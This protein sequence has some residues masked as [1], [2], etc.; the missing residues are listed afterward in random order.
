MKNKAKLFIILAG[1]IAILGALWW[2]LR[3]TE[4]ILHAPDSRGLQRLRTETYDT[5]FLSTFPVSEYE[6]ADYNHFRNMDMVKANVCMVTDKILNVHLHTAF[7]SRNKIDTAYLGVQP[8]KLSSKEVEALLKAQPKTFFEIILPYPQMDYWTGMGDKQLQD[9][10]KCYRDFATAM[11]SHEN[12]RVYLF[13]GTEWLVC[14]P[15]NYENTFNTNKDISQKIM[16]NTDEFH[17]FMLTS[18]QLDTVFNDMYELIRSYKE[19]P[20]QYPDASRWDI[21]FLGDSVIG[22]YA[23]S[24][25]VPGVVQGLTGAK[26][27][28]CG[29]GGRG[30]AQS[31]YTPISLPDVV[32]CITSGDASPLPQEEQVGKGVRAFLDRETPAEN[33]MFVINHGLNDYFSGVP[34]ETAQAYDI[35]SYS[36]ALRTAIA[37]LQA[38][39]P[40]ARI[41]LNTSNFTSYFKNG[42]EIQSD[43]G[44]QLIDYVEAVSV[45]AKDMGVAVL[46]I[47]HIL[48]IDADNHQLYLT[49]GCHPNDMTRFY[50]GSLIAELIE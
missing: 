48:P 6:E 31:E 45:V 1:I 28:N 11:L 36:G 42:T 13:S 47:Y 23:D 5:I 15:S 33:I 32:N 8:D 26:V 29:Y 7:T 22:N 16:L 9:M 10:I 40:N 20:L 24:S 44:G 3:P 12:A 41:L 19:A 46:D 2:S 21:V 43:V 49:D 34:V 50:L 4:K 27:Y 38:H 14:N 35:T 37:D 25:S 18:E 17:G 39:F 30:A